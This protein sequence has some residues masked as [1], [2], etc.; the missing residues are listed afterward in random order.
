M[1]DALMLVEHRMEG[2]QRE[3]D[4]LRRGIDNEKLAIEAVRM[5]K[6]QRMLSHDAELIDV[7]TPVHAKGCTN[8]ST[9]KCPRCIL[10]FGIHNGFES[11]TTIRL[12]MDKVVDDD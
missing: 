10:M 8:C 12:L 6:L 11:N 4:I 3:A 7:L 1:Q 9:S 5:A 2:L